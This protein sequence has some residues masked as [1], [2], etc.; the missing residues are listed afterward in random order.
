M[1]R[2]KKSVSV[3]VVFQIHSA[4]EPRECL[5]ERLDEWVSE[6]MGVVRRGAGV[7]FHAAVR[8]RMTNAPLCSCPR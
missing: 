8:R 4:G 2:K 7:M 3:C 6:Q 1:V 5:K